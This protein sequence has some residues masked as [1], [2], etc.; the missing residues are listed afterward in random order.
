MKKRLSG[1]ILLASLVTGASAYGYEVVKVT[2]GGSVS[3]KVTFTGKDPG[4]E[5]YPVTKDP[6]VCGHD[7]R[8]ID[9]VKV[10]K[11]A[12]TEVVVYLSKVE[13]GKDFPAD[14]PRKPVITQKGCQFQPYLAFMRDGDELTVVNPDG[15]LHNTHLYEMMK[16]GRRSIYNMN[17]PA[18]VREI[19][20]PVNLTRG[21]AVKVECDAH[22]FMHSYI[23]VAQNPYYALVKDDGS[24]TID[25]IPPGEYKVKAWHPTLGEESE[26][27]QLAAG[28]AAKVDFQFK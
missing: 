20:T 25:N 12:L 5:N 17:Q 28:A 27:T 24:Y 26:K 2:G 3:G 22:D 6:H 10:N 18:N 15:I 16:N 21:T 23:F 1:F 8:K 14:L 19:S 7:A 13:K 4:P 11:G 9:F